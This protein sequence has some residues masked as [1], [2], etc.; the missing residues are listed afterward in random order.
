M[1]LEI[2]Q[3]TGDPVADLK[4][5]RAEL[6]KRVAKLK[7]EIVNRDPKA[8]LSAITQAVAELD[9][10]IIDAEANAKAEHDAKLVRFRSNSFAGHL[11]TDFWRDDRGDSWVKCCGHSAP[12]AAWLWDIHASDYIQHP[13]IKQNQPENRMKLRR[14]WQRE[15]EERNAELEAAYKAVVRIHVEYLNRLGAPPAVVRAYMEQANSN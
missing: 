2:R 3:S 11:I 4:F 13:E 10:K 9:K 6:S 15:D 8:E 14:K 5:Q 7:F 1:P 12:I